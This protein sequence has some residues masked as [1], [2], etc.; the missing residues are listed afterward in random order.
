MESYNSFKS[1]DGTNDRCN[2]VWY[3]TWADKLV[4]MHP[5]NTAREL[6]DVED[7]GKKIRSISDVVISIQGSLPFHGK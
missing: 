4:F 7:L 2:A 1:L 3:C 6:G 5:R